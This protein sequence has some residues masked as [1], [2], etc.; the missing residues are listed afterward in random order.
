M[1]S[2]VIEEILPCYPS[3]V[4]SNRPATYPMHRHLILLDSL[5]QEQINFWVA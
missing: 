2:P 5:F 3:H 1:V 4:D